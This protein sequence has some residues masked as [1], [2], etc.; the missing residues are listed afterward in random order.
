MMMSWQGNAF[1]ITHPLYGKFPGQEGFVI[2]EGYLPLGITKFNV[3]NSPLTGY[4][5]NSLAPG[6]CVCTIN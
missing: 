4:K 2:L 6:R 5:F 3:H 1:H